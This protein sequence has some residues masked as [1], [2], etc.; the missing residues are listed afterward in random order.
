ME[1]PMPALPLTAL[2]A[3]LAPAAV[4]PA[5]AAP[6]AP[7]PA[8][9]PGTWR[10]ESL[11]DCEGDLDRW[12][13]KDGV[14]IGRTT[15]ERPLAR[16]AYLWIPGK[17]AD[18]VLTCRFRI[19]GGNSG[20]Q[21]R[22]DPQ[23]TGEPK[24]FQADVDAA[25]AYTGRL[26]EGGEGGRGLVNERGERVQFAADGSRQSLRFLDDGKAL[27]AIRS[28]EW[29]EYRIEAVGG[30][31]RHSINGTLV[32]EVLEAAPRRRTGRI[33]FQLHVGEP[34]AV[35]YAEVTI[36]PVGASAPR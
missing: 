17:H 16:N 27:A 26:Y 24:G 36:R 34:M 13:L 8:A 14:L 30:T 18:F 23:E 9:L 32:T 19:A 4:P 28:G 1:T 31:V 6:S 25:N 7:A 10:L 20:I 35:E 21:Y 33:G 29:N 2:L 12:E 11:E 3:L 5:P 15:A 22:T